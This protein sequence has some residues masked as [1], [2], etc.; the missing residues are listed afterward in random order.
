[1]GRGHPDGR[2]VSGQAGGGGHP[3]QPHLP[4][5]ERERGGD[6]HLHQPLQTKGD[7]QSECKAAAVVGWM[8]ETRFVD[9]M[10]LV[11]SSRQ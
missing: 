3:V 5:R 4:D 11:S 10:P 9:I 6:G 8:M 7:V 2:R 1:M